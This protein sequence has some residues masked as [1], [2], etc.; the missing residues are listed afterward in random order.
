MRMR[1]NLAVVMAVAVGVLAGCGEQASPKPTTQAVEGAGTSAKNSPVVRLAL[2]WVAEPEFGGFYAAKEKGAYAQRSLEVEIL[3]GG[4]GAP[5]VQMIASGQVEFG[6]VSADEVIIARSKGA[7]VVGLFAVYQTNP[8]GIMAHAERGLRTLEE[9]F[10]SGTV[11]VEPGLPYVKFLRQLYGQPGAQVVPYAGGVAAFL[12][13]KNFAQQCF[14]FSE[15]LAAKRQG[16]QPQVFLIAESGYNPYAGVVATSGAYLKEHE[17]VV[18]AFVAATREGWRDYLA[19]PGP[20]NAVM[21]KLNSAMD[22]DTFAQAAGAQAGLL[23]SA[24]TKAGGLGVMTE[25]RWET[26]AKQL[27]EL[28]VIDRAVAAGECFRNY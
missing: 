6:I 5:V 22:A 9:A 20:A 24:E 17:D 18:K 15:P 14:V 26:L 8:Q 1:K 10:K 21:G 27:R 4:A 19:D 25:E 13:D 3:P 28:G 16:V 2:N 7:D 12:N 11:A 23:E